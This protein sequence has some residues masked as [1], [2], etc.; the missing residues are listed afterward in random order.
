LIEAEAA[1]Q[2]FL[3]DGAG[4]LAEHDLHGVAGH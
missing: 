1:A 4:G 2:L 3:I